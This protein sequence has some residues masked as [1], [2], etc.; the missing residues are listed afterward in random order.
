MRLWPALLAAALPAVLAGP[1]APPP[2]R[3]ADSEQEID[4]DFRA[5]VVGDYAIVGRRPDGGPPYAGTAR[6]EQRGQALVLTRRIGAATTVYEGGLE[7]AMPPMDRPR[8]FRFRWTDG[9]AKMLM[10]CLM[11]ADLANYPRLTCEWGEPGAK[12]PGLEAYF[13]RKRAD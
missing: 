7:R 10:T 5:F 1:A 9:K 13:H 2:A 6:I 3:A 8:V 12:D 11:R 4:E